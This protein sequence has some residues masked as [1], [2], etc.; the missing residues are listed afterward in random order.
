MFK[1]PEAAKQS[2]PTEVLTD[3]LLNTVALP[4]GTPPPDDDNQ[5]PSLL[6]H[7]K[8]HCAP[9][10]RWLMTD[11]EAQLRTKPGRFEDQRRAARDKAQKVVDRLR[12]CGLNTRT[13]YLVRRNA[14]GRT[15]IEAAF[16]LAWKR[17]ART[18]ILAPVPMAGNAKVSEV[19]SVRQQTVA[20]VLARTYDR[21]WHVFVLSVEGR[22]DDPKVLENLAVKFSDFVSARHMANLVALFGTEVSIGLPAPADQQLSVRRMRWT[23]RLD[24]AV[25]TLVRA[26]S[27]LVPY[28]FRAEIELGGP[29]PAAGPSDRTGNNPH[30]GR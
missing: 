27:G 16:V 18:A 22:L 1:H 3:E 30:R 12:S 21:G 29:A 5:L 11:E 8:E 23:A 20:S 14:L 4:P 15:Q 10:G 26:L 13:A 17:E 2:N 6:K 9:T 25:K 7:L 19:A 28:R 24:R